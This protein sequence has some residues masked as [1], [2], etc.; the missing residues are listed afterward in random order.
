MAVDNDE[1][2]FAVDPSGRVTSHNEPEAHQPTS[3]PAIPHKKIRA[4]FTRSRTHN[5]Q[6][7]VA[8]CGM[9]LGRDTM[10]SAEGVASVA[11]SPS[12]L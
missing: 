9:I 10:F 1:E 7:A 4:K 6:L 5:E 8:P 11:V 12:S 2:I 3:T